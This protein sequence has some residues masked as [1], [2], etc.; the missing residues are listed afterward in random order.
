[1]AYRV[2]CDENVDPQTV[3]YLGRDGHEAAHVGTALPLSVGDDEIAAHARE[4][5]YVV[6]TNDTDFL[7]PSVYPDVTV[8]LY[9]D[10]R[11][12]AHEL[13][14]MVSELTTYYP[15]QDDLPRENYPSG[16]TD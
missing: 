6:L 8:L 14:A 5:G 3:Q 11:A 4:N 1:M 16:K 10:H 13:A 7:G 15:S 9:T 12:S 2:L